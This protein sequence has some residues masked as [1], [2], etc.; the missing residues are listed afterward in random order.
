MSQ[1]KIVLRVIAREKKNVLIS[2]EELYLGSLDFLALSS[3]CHSF[4]EMNGISRY[5]PCKPIF[6]YSLTLSF[7][8]YFATINLAN[9]YLLLWVDLLNPSNFVLGFT[10][11][12]ICFRP[13]T[14]KNEPQMVFDSWHWCSFGKVMDHWRLFFWK[15]F[16]ANWLK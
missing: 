6:M 7:A 16:L 9:N 14:A 3:S 5:F 1:P 2:R 12:H 4:F 8:V 13:F 15:K 11:C 10:S